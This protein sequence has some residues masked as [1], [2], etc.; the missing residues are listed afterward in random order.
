MTHS[1]RVF[2]SLKDNALE[3]YLLISVSDGAVTPAYTTETPP[4]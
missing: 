4:E 1:V 3:N 2:S